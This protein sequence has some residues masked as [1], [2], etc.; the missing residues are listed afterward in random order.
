MIVRCKLGLRS[1]AIWQH[2]VSP[3]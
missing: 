1:K 3:T 2:G